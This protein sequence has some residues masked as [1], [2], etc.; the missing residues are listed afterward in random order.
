MAY[1]LAFVMLGLSLAP[2]AARGGAWPLALWPALAFVGAGVAYAL[3][4]PRLLGKRPDGTLRP[5]AL[6]AFLPYFALVWLVWLVSHA[7]GRQR[8]AHEIVPGVFLGRWPPPPRRRT[9][10]G[11]APGGLPPA[12]VRSESTTKPTSALRRYSRNPRRVRGTP[13]RFSRI[14]PGASWNINRYG[15]IGRRA[16]GT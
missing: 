5:A 2:L 14:G 16:P 6:V 13:N 7:L 1:A 15:S 12:K 11:L 4:A 8:H 10:D 9:F 3:G